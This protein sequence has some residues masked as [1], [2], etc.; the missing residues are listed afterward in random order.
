MKKFAY[1]GTD[2]DN[3]ESIIKNGLEPRVPGDKISF[4]TRPIIFYA[5][6]PLLAAHYAGFTG[7]LLRF[8][9]P[10][11][12]RFV[13]K[14]A[15]YYVTYKHIA[16]QNIE[17]FMAGIKPKRATLNELL[18]TDNWTNIKNYVK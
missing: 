15:L 18:F 16:P 9:L 7:I 8:D 2:I 14:D 1:H 17:I 11:D 10:T 5:I 6:D 13:A 12:G 3:L 4:G